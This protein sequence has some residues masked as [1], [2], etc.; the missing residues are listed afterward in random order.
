MTSSNN[1]LH[2]TV[3]KF[4]YALAST[5]SWRVAFAITLIITVSL[6]EGIGLLLLLPLMQ[7]VGLDLGQSN[8]GR[9]TQLAN[10]TLSTLGVNPTLGG[11][12]GVYVLVTAV[13]ALFASW[14]TVF[15]VSVVNG[16][17]N[18][19]RTQLYEDIARTSWSFF[20]R[21]RAS[22]FIHVLTSEIDRISIATHF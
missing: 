20:C 7:L 10:E 4:V 13:Q 21:S 14:Q 9:L 18:Q 19:L 16:F 6:T 3:R 12:L 8:A 1:A 17:V 22:D 11:V 5:M 15:N 2:S